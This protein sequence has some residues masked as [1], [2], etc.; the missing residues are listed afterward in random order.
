MIDGAQRSGHPALS[1]VFLESGLLGVGTS[2]LVRSAVDLSGGGA[3]VTSNNKLM[4]LIRELDAGNAWAVGR[5]D[6]LAS[7]AQL[8]AG[9]SANLPAV[10]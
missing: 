10:S 2:S 3:N 8:P 7:R 5:F 4:S 6:A 9:V 1:V